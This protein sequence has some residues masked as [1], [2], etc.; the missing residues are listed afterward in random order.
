MKC[1]VRGLLPTALALLSVLAPGAL[2]AAEPPRFR[3]TLSEAVDRALAASARLRALEQMEAGAAADLRGARAERMPAV[4]LR[5]GYTRRSDVPELTIATPG[6][7][8]RTIFPNLPD[9]YS[10]RLGLSLTLYAGGRIAAAVEAARE[11]Q[12]AAGKEREAARQDLVLETHAAY[13][14]LVTARESER[15]LSEGLAAFE[16]HLKDARNRQSVGMAAANEVLAVQVERDRAELRRLRAENAAEL[17]EANLLRLL[18]LDFGTV[19]EA[20]DSLETAPAPSQD[21]EAL[22]SAAVES[23]PERSRQEA[24]IR[25]A[26]ARVRIQRAARLPQVSAAAG[27]DH[28]NPNRLILPAEAEWNHTWDLGLQVSLKVFDG[29][30]TSAAVARAQAEAEAGRHRLEDL[31]RQIRLQVTGAHLDL[32]AAQAAVGVANQGL[33]AARE[34]H[35][36]SQDRY[37]EGVIPSSELLDASVALLQAG[38]DRTQ[39]LAQVCIAAAELDRAVGR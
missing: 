8:P 21:L 27:F 5:A 28:A 11:N 12:E 26:E 35:R 36:V 18:D 23:R 4:D 13:W 14:G 2:T 34:N 15:V 29:G 20:A 16:A 19:L 7:P 10:A 9:N 17:A 39:A 22:V 37:R 30:R 31:D 24:L 33:G 3:L 1:R 32:R 6:G 25:A 38:L